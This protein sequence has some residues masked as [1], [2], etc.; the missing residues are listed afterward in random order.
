M[1]HN[2]FVMGALL[3]A[4]VLLAGGGRAQAQGYHYGYYY[5]DENK[6]VS[7]YQRPI[8]Q[9]MSAKQFAE[10]THTY[11]PSAGPRYTVASRGPA[12]GYIHVVVADTKAK[13][14]FDGAATQATG[15]DRLFETPLLS[16]GA[17]YPYR[18]RATW[19]VNGTEVTRDRTISVTP[20]E[21]TLV[22]FSREG[23]EKVSA[24][25]RP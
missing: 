18:V 15:T 25:Q 16:R 19:T 3:G 2:R 13:V 8:V 1:W 11:V 23:A 22:D 21:T 10:L 17:T 12:E 20:G 7:S 6:W 24:P 9:Y 5:P 4:V 14:W